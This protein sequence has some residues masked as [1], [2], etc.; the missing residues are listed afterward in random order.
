MLFVDCWRSSVWLAFRFMHK[1]TCTHIYN[2]ISS[3]YSLE[4]NLAFS[5]QET[6]GTPIN[7]LSCY[8]YSFHWLFSDHFYLFFRK[9]DSYYLY[10][11]FFPRYI[12]FLLSIHCLYERNNLYLF[13]TITIWHLFSSSTVYFRLILNT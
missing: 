1:S 3:K 6:C 12:Q 7:T 8:S 13:R 5:I 11:A 2:C 10:L 9:H 4:K